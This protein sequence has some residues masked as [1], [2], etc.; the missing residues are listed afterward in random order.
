MTF[1]FMLARLPQDSS[2]KS[3]FETKNCALLP[4]CLRKCIPSSRYPLTEK[5]S[6]KFIMTVPFYKSGG[7][8]VVPGAGGALPLPLIGHGEPSCCLHIVNTLDNSEG[9]D[10]VTSCSPLSR[11][12]IF[13]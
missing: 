13:S 4:G 1:D 10:H 2:I 12:D 7:V 3:C 6:S 5:V 11:I 8:P 9:L